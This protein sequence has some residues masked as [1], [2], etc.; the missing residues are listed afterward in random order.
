MKKNKMD[1]PEILTKIL[2]ITLIVVGISLP[3]ICCGWSIYVFIKY[4]NAPIGEI[5]AWAL[6]FMFRWR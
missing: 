4:G 5:P 1:L 3:L 6:W 2:S